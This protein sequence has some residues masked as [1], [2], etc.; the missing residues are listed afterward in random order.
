MSHSTRWNALCQALEAE[1]SRLDALRAHAA[2]GADIIL[3]MDIPG[4]ERWTSEQQMLLAELG[5]L[6]EARSEATRACLNAR[7]LPAVKSGLAERVTFLT[8]LRVAPGRI[9]DRLRS[10]RQR[11]SGL[12]DDLALVT[13]RNEVL[14]RQVLAF[15]DELGQSLVA[16][17]PS[18]YDAS[19]QLAADGGGALLELSL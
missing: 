19:G 10:L 2:T 3:T 4:L 6:A 1:A 13:S 16:G 8:L 12:R 18:G 11:L 7:A 15:T 9:A 17:E 14:L 5:R